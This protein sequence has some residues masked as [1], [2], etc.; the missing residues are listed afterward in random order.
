MMKVEDTGRGM[1]AA[2]QD[3]A[4]VVD[5]TDLRHEGETRRFQ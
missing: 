2:T 5:Q 1:D 3:E 4:E